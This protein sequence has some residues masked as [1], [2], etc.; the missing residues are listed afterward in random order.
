MKGFLKFIAFMGSRPHPL[1]SAISLAARTGGRAFAVVNIG[2]YGTKVAKARY[3]AKGVLELNDVVF[4][5]PLAGE[6]SSSV[7]IS[8][9]A[10]QAARQR[11]ESG[12][13]VVGL[14]DKF[15]LKSQP[16]D[17]ELM[18]RSATTAFGDSRDLDRGMV[19][20][21]QRSALIIRAGIEHS[22]ADGIE[23]TLQEAGLTVLRTMVPLF[24]LL[25]HVLGR[26]EFAET[27]ELPAGIGGRAAIVMDQRW[28]VL[29]IWNRGQWAKV[30]SSP[31]FQGVQQTEEEEEA[32]RAMLDETA[33]MLRVEGALEIIVADSGTPSDLFARL[34][35]AAQASQTAPIVLRRACRVRDADLISLCE[36]P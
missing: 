14:A 13:V 29:V 25:N 5:T 22:L 8:R 15:S 33:Q 20:G 34:E 32:L 9:Q 23:A 6:T 4:L 21:N 10:V 26:P 24:T 19:M 27:A 30:R 36:H 12:F 28:L 17:V 31:M 3:T 16:F 35:R 18:T 7:Q 2:G 1:N 11:S